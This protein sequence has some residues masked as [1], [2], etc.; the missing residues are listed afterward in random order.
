[1]KQQAPQVPERF[2]RCSVGELV[3]SA[4]SAA[5]L[6]YGRVTSVPDAECNREALQQ[7]LL[8]VPVSPFEGRAAM[9]C[10]PVRW[11]IMHRCTAPLSARAD[12][13]SGVRSGRVGVLRVKMPQISPMPADE[14]RFWVKLFPGSGL[15]R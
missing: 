3:I 14:S 15:P 13:S 1:M 6:E 2:A 12:T 8:E 11:A 9:A 4:I 10:G 5:E 7:F